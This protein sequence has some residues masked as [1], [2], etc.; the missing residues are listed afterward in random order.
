[1]LAV[2]YEAYGDARVLNIERVARPVPNEDQVLIKVRVASVNPLDWHYMRGT[3]YIMRIQSGFLAPKTPRLGS[4]VA[5]DVVAV[6]ANVTAFKVGD[7]VFGGSGAAFGEYALARAIRIA[8]KPD[9]MTYEQAASIPVAALT[10]L[11]ALRDIGQVKAGTRVLINGAS[12]GVGTFAIQIAKAL[13]ADVTAVC[14]TRNVELVSSLGADRVIDYIKEDFAAAG[15]TYDVTYDLVGNRSISDLRTVTAENGIVIMSGGGS[16]ADG[17]LFGPLTDTAWAYITSPFASQRLASPLAEV[18]TED[19]ATIAAMVT[20]K[21][22]TPVIDRTYP[23]A[24]I[25]DAIHYIE[26]GRARGKV[27]IAVAPA[28]GSDGAPAS[29]L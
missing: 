14:S 10:A 29:P 7:A 23:L 27:V 28:E 22:L 19:L 4:D 3:P 17:G 9:D 18:K 13:D 11:Q 6:G 20:A 24:E 12:G 15:Q 25:A 26:S 1:M 21:T 8:P 2:T 5:G 16:P